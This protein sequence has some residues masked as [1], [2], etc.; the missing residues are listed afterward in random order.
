LFS[1]RLSSYKLDELNP[2]VDEKT[3]EELRSGLKGQANELKI[4]IRQEQ[5]KINYLYH[6]LFGSLFKAGQ[7]SSRF[8]RQVMRSNPDIHI[9]IVL[10]STYLIG[11]MVVYACLYTSRASNLGNASPDK[12][13]RPRRDMLPHDLDQMVYQKRKV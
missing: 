12:P 5:K 11:Q 10:T 8:A 2:E 6:P 1:S 3:R 9:L 4:L 13:Y 7:Q